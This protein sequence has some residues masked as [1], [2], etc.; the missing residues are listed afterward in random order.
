MT[1]RP[2]EN[3]DELPE[4]PTAHGTGWAVAGFVCA[5]AALLLLPLVVGAVGMIAGTIAHLKQSRLGMPAA[6]ASGIT[7]VLGTA[8][9]F[10]LRS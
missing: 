5:A 8:N 1:D 4:I 3:P 2:D 6:I 7:L 10:L 9:E